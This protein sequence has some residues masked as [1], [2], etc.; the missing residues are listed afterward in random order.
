MTTSIFVHILKRMSELKDSGNRECEG[1]MQ[2]FSA[3]V[4]V[5]RMDTEIDHTE[6]VYCMGQK[7]LTLSF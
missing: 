3:A 4:T 2:L 5:S 7:M 6:K 1:Q